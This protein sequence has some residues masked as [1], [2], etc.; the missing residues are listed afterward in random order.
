[1]ARKQKKY[2]YIYK[3]TCNVTKRYYIGMHSTDNLDDGYMGSGKRLRASIRKY[4]KGNHTIEILE[5]YNTREELKLREEM[6]VNSDLVKEDNCMNLVIGG[7]GFMLDDWHYTCSKFGN[8][9]LNE[10]LKN[11]SEFRKEWLKKMKSGVQK[12]MDEGRMTKIQDNYTW[13][14]K[15]HSEETKQKISDS[16]KGNG[17]GKANSQYGTCWVSNGKEAKKINLFELDNYLDNGWV[18]GKL[19]N[20]SEII[21]F[22]EAGNSYGRTAKEFNI[23]K[24]TIVNNIKNYYKWKMK[25]G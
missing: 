7:G 21:E 25:E 8:K 5:F 15:K 24:G 18:K 11:D 22:Y 16:M 14:G 19:A 4:G 23:P 6:I 10:K 12:A 20:I 13:K 1:M 17:V 3:T 9:V 2:H